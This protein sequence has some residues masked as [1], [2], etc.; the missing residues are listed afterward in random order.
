MWMP[1]WRRRTSTGMEGLHS[2]LS[3]WTWQWFRG[4]R[5]WLTDL[6]RVL[7]A[8]EHRVVWYSLMWVDVLFSTLWL[9]NKIVHNHNAENIIVIMR[10]QCC[11]Y[12]PSLPKVCQRSATMWMYL[13]RRSSTGMEG[14]HSLLSIWTCQR[15]SGQRLWLANQK[16]C[17]MHLNIASSTHSC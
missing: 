2:L 4:Q 9:F 11:N 12:T 1:L 15:F 6:E 8:F 17:S 10:N 13:R 5:L 16:G 7:H 14:L 3:V